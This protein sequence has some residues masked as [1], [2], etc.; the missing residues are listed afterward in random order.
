MQHQKKSRKFALKITNFGM[1]ETNENSTF[2][3]KREYSPIGKRFQLPSLKAFC[4]FLARHGASERTMED[5]VRY[6]GFQEWEYQ[7]IASILANELQLP[8]PAQGDNVY[9]MLDTDDRRY[10]IATMA[11]MGMCANTTRHRF[12]HI[13]F[14]QWEMIGINKLYDQFV[15]ETE[16]GCNSNSLK[17]NLRKA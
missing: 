16:Q 12:S 1:K 5:R 13:N 4:T 11:D 3:K 14:A 8:C 2:F 10:L 6:R 15:A 9:D 17:K 7:G